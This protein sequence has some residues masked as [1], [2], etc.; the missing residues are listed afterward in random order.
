MLTVSCKLNCQNEMKWISWK[1][2]DEGWVNLNT[3]GVVGCLHQY[4][5]V[6]GG[7]ICDHVGHWKRGFA[8]NLDNCGVLEAKLWAILKGL[9]VCWELGFRRVRVNSDSMLVVKLINANSTH[10][11]M[12]RSLVMAIRA[13]LRKEWSVDV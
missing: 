9:E 10:V 8:V 5:P 4:V 11:N 7:V 12:H 2:P 13:G 3:D 1:P 6:V